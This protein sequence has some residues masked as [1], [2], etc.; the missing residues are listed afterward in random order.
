VRDLTILFRDERCVAID[1]P[2][3]ML[4]HRTKESTDRVFVLQTLRDQ[5]GQH[6]Y[7]VHRLD[8]PASGVIAFGLDS[9]SARELQESMGD[10]LKEY[11]VMVRGETAPSFSSDRELSSDKGVKQSAFTEFELIETKRGFSLIKARL[12]TGRRHQIR[13]HL[14]HLGHQVVGDTAH[15]KGRINRWLRDEYGLPRLFLHAHRLECSMVRATAP[16]PDDLAGFLQ[17]FF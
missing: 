8:R 9:E 13:R 6:V 17:R 10:G 1:K 5:I 11:L 4:V 2:P 12:G 15:G 3:G 16:L 7:P 14:S